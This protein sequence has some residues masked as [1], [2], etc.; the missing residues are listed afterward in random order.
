MVCGAVLKVVEGVDTKEYISLEGGGGRAWMP[1]RQR[2][3]TR[4]GQASASQHA[5]GLQVP[6]TNRQL[7]HRSTLP[8]EKHCLERGEGFAA[9]G[10]I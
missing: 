10:A 2:T 4:A 9:E 3:S 8:F 7:F 6:H 5:A 1:E